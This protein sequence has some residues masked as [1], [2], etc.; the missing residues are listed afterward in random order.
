MTTKY[1]RSSAFIGNKRSSTWTSPISCSRRTPALKVRGAFAKTTHFYAEEESRR[2]EMKR[3]KEVEHMEGLKMQMSAK[4]EV[5]PKGMMEHE[6]LLNKKLLEMVDKK[7][8]SMLSKRKE[9][10]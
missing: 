7:S 8:P 4:R 2:K 6:Y 1:R 3:Q 10:F 5:I 9:G